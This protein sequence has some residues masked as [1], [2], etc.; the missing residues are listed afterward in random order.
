MEGQGQRLRDKEGTG[1]IARIREMIDVYELT[2]EDL[3]DKRK[4]SPFR[5][6]RVTKKT[7]SATRLFVKYG[8]GKGDT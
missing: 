4:P 6:A 3:F 2:V 5:K 7:Q 8:D 1:V